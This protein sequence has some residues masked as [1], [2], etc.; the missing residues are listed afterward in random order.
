[1]WSGSSGPRSRSEEIRGGRKAPRI[2][3]HTRRAPMHPSAGPEK[4]TSMEIVPPVISPELVRWLRSLFPDR[5]PDEPLT[6]EQY[7]V[8]VGQQQVIR[9]IER[10]VSEQQDNLLAL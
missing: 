6:K 3:L 9:R 7:D 1:M 2:F 4:R 10:Q 5:I 8:L